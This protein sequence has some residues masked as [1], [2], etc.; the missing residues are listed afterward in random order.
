MITFEIPRRG[1]LGMTL[2]VV[3]KSSLLVTFSDPEDRAI[4]PLNY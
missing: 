1:L 4:E 3:L 2:S